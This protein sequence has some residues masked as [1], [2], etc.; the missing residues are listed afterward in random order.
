MR[1]PTPSTTLARFHARWPEELRAL[2][3]GRFAP[4]EATDLLVG[5]GGGIKQV[6]TFAEQ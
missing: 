1:S 6:L 4:T 5:P 2:I 3:T